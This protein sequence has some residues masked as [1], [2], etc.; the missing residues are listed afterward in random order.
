MTRAGIQTPCW[1]LVMEEGVD[2][3]SPAIAKTVNKGVRRTDCA[4]EKRE[5]LSFQKKLS[6]SVCLPTNIIPTCWEENFLIYLLIYSFCFVLNRVQAG[7]KLDTSPKESLKLLIFSL[8]LPSSRITSPSHQAWL[9]RN[10]FAVPQLAYFLS[11]CLFVANFVAP[12]IFKT[13]K[14]FISCLNRAAH[15]CLL[16]NMSFINFHNFQMVCFR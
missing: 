1:L 11:I 2:S 9:Q 4:Q 14:L 8:H 3:K 15:F 16:R 10:W 6:T 13:M 5:K 12:E 7:P